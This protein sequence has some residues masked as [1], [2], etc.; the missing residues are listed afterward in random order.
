MNIS[1]IKKE[2][3][4]KNTVNLITNKFADFNKVYQILEERIKGALIISFPIVL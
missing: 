2:Y 3:I 1:K 4:L